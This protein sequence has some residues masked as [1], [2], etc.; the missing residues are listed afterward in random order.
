M[1]TV[2]NRPKRN[3]DGILDLDAYL[4]NS[5][6]RVIGMTQNVRLDD[7]SLRQAHRYVLLHSDEMKPVIQ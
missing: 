1:E 2:L 7:R 6:G 4:Y 5:G 3:D